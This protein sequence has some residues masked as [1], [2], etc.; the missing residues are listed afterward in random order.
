[1][2][3]QKINIRNQD[4]T[5]WVNILTTYN[6][7]LKDS[8]QYF[9]S[10]YLDEALIELHERF[11]MVVT[12]NESLTIYIAQ[13]IFILSNNDVYL[14]DA[15]NST[16]YNVAGFVCSNEILS[17]SQGFIKTE[18]ILETTIANWNNVI[19][20]SDGTTGLYEGKN[21]FLSN[22]TPGKITYIA[23]SDQPGHYVVPIGRA[24]TQTHFKIDIDPAI[25]L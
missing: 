17:G 5:D 23:P 25:G 18:G 1:M 20:T 14:A 21:Y 22:I 3:K 13:P 24:L 2:N 11:M 16:R 12:N 4:N 8:K 10:D 15:S 7:E 6:I 9:N 19:E